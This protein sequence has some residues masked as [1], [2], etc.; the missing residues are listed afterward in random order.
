MSA[1]FRERQ[2][3]ASRKLITNER[4]VAFLRAVRNESDLHAVRFI[5]EYLDGGEDLDSIFVTGDE[6]GFSLEVKKHSETDFDISFGCQVAPMA[7]D[8]GRWLVQFDGDRIAVLKSQECWI[9]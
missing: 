7:G 3:R 8:G 1:N 4:I 2:I 5:N 6:F 9:S